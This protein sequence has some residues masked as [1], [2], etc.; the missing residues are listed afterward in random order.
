MEIESLP[1]DVLMSAAK[2]PWID[3]KPLNFL[4]SCTRE[5]SFGVVLFHRVELLQ[6]LSWIL[7]PPPFVEQLRK[8]MKQSGLHFYKAGA[9]AD[10]FRRHNPGFSMAHTLEKNEKNALPMP[11]SRKRKSN[12]KFFS[13]G[14]QELESVFK[15]N[16][17]RKRLDI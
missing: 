9:L 1:K 16:K 4:G 15:E 11:Q 17:K 3:F 10:M 8:V 5:T 13:D 12:E 14:L 6:A 7:D 2:Q